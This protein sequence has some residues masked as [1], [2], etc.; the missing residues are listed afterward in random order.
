MEKRKWLF[1]TIP[2]ICAMLIIILDT[3]TAMSGAIEGIQLC[4]WT[5][6]PSLFPFFILSGIINSNLLGISIRPLR[7]LTKLCK[8]PKGGESLLLLGYFA[9]YP[10]GAQLITQEYY[11]GKLSAE[12]ACLVCSLSYLKIPL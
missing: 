4:I 3:K 12:T 6:L 10:V 9:G 11:N 1:R 5:V 7:P 2:A 8:I